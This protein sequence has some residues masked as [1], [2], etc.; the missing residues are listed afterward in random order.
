MFIDRNN[1][2]DY[3]ALRVWWDPRKKV[4]Q[5]TPFT[6]R[7]GRTFAMAARYPSIKDKS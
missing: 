6:L 7:K 1:R 5:G 2:T 4:L 3:G